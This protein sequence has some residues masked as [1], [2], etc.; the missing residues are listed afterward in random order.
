MNMWVWGATLRVLGRQ[1]PPPPPPK[2]ASGQQL[3]AKGAALSS[4]WAR[5]N[6]HQS[7]LSETSVHFAP[8]HPRVLK[9]GAFLNRLEWVVHPPWMK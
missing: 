9:D 5:R 4:P 1:L 2:G 8:Q 3:V 6:M 7:H